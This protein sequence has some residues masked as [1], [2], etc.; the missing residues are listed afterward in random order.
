MSVNSV[1]AIEVTPT[2]AALGAD[3]TG[4]DLSAPLSDEILAR[5]TEIWAQYLVLRFPGQDVADEKL[6]A[7]SEHFGGPQSGG[8]RKRRLAMGF[9]EHSKNNSTDMRV[10]YVTNLDP[11][12][13]PSATPRGNGAYELRW[14][15]DNTYV[16]VPPT[17][18]LLWGQ[19]IPIDGSGQTLFC[20][21][22]LAYEEL[23]GDLKAAIEGKHMMHDG[24]RNTANKVQMGLTAPKTQEEIEGPVHPI[25]RIHP[26]TG[27]RAL[28]LGRRWDFP[29]TY[30]IEMPGDEGEALMDRLWAH[31]TQ[32]KYVWVQDWTSGDLV[33]W[34]NRA[35]MHRREAVN[36]ASPRVM[37]RTL[38]KG[39]PVISAWDN[40]VAA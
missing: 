23:P 29:S 40:T 21:Q 12:G 2:G 27:K 39:D 22:I 11:E 19:K 30:I 3:V 36:P 25:V 38:I 26:P 28:F 20:N 33:M 6:I 16:E 37:H 15:S 4:I 8:A 5:L 31:A 13:N 32:E 34:D 17:A 7:F 35:V 1:D 14:H 24:S 10:N 18:T 9:G